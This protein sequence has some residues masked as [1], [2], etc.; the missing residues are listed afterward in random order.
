MTTLDSIFHDDVIQ[1]YPWPVAPAQV[2]HVYS[3]NRK[4]SVGEQ[5]DFDR[6]VSLLSSLRADV[7]TWYKQETGKE[8]MDTYS[9]EE[10]AAAVREKFWH[11]ARFKEAFTLLELD[12][13]K[14]HQKATIPWW[15]E[16]AA[17]ELDHRLYPD[18]H[19]VGIVFGPRHSLETQLMRSGIERPIKNVSVGGII[20][21]APEEGTSTHEIVLGLRGGAAYSNTYH[22][23][24]GALMATAEFRTGLQTVYDLFRQKE[25][26]P[27]F[28]IADTDVVAARLHSRIYDPVIDRGP[29]YV[30]VVETKLRKNEIHAR[31]EKNLNPDKKEH[32]APL[33]LPNTADAINEFIR[34]NYRGVVANR[35]RADHERYLLH[36]GALA[37]ASYSRMPIAELRSLFREGN[38]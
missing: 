35:I 3:S 28:G 26:L 36:P 11:D 16:V 15:N 37:L 18:M 29:M 21:T 14:D 13:E 5:Y 27:E 38:W 31:W 20:V 17:G 30:F 7:E 10:M 19:G 33:Y 2:M 6:I 12:W 23:N 25:L 22:I 9:L 34:A 4:N 24:A 8:K 1:V 32:D